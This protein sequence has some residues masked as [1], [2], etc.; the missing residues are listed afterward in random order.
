MVF[1]AIR[2]GSPAQLF[3]KGFKD[4]S[5]EAQAQ[6]QC[7][8]QKG[9]EKQNGQHV[10]TPVVW[11]ATYCALDATDRDGHKQSA[12]GQMPPTRFQAKAGVTSVNF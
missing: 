11:L 9:D 4:N 7:Q 1:S 5:N 3:K 2:L 8:G 12:E 6:P 10:D